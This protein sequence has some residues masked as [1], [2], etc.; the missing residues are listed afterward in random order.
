MR[1][2]LLFLLLATPLYADPCADHF[3]AGLRVARP[4]D[5]WLGETEATL[6]AGLGW[7]TRAR[8]MER[9]EARSAVTNACQEAAILR[10]DLHVAQDRLLAAQRSFQLAAAL[11]WDINRTRAQRNLAALDDQA[12]ALRDMAGYIETLD[13][14]CPG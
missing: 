7:V 12:V 6:Y 14:R 4:L 11:C 9:L 5:V 10:R 8:V 2:V 13:D 1:L 3:R